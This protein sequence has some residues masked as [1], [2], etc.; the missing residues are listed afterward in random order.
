MLKKIGHTSII[1]SDLD[2]ISR[3]EKYILPGVGSFDEGMRNLLKSGI[4]NVL[5]HEVCVGKK[6]LLGICLGMQLLTTKSEEGLEAGLGWIE[7]ETKRFSFLG[8]EKKLPIPH[9]GWNSIK[10][11]QNSTLFSGLSGGQRFYFTHSFHVVCSNPKDVVAE[12]DYGGVFVCAVQKDN[13]MGVQFHPEKSHSF[14]MAL[15][16]NFCE[17]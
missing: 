5:N 12:S 14:G 17:A 8:Q 2:L 4:L 7:A 15:L 1:S 11:I 13:I 6:K 10:V 3:G 9:M 16:K